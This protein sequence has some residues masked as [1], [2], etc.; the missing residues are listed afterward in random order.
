MAD[1][2]VNELSVLIMGR[3][4]RIVAS[5]AELFINLNLKGHTGCVTLRVPVEKFV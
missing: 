1:V 3:F 4:A 5:V 2:I